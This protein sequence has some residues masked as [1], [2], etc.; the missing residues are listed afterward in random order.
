M[1]RWSFGWREE[2]KPPWN[3]EAFVFSVMDFL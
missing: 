1:A 3:V 2:E